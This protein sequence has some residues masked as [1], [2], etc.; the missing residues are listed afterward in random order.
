MVQVQ[1]KIRRTELRGKRLKDF[2]H[3]ARISHNEGGPFDNRQFCFGMID[4]QTDEL[5]EECQNC[6]AHVRFANEQL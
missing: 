3:K 6:K 5:I 4:K 1:K 2:C